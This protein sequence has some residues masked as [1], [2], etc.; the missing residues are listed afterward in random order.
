M[1]GTPGSGRLRRWGPLLFVA[2]VYGVLGLCLVMTKSRTALLGVLVAAGLYWFVQRTGKWFRKGAIAAIT[3]ILAGMAL[4]TLALL[5][6]II[7][8]QVLSEAPKSLKYRLEYWAATSRMILDHIWLGCGPGN[9]RANYLHHKLAGASEEILDP[10][11]LLLDVWA[12][13]GIVAW[14]GLVALLI[15]GVR[16]GWR[17]VVGESSAGIANRPL[18]LLRWSEGVQCAL[19]GPALVILQQVGFGAGADERMWVFLMACPF[20]GGWLTAT[21]TGMRQAP[22]WAAWIALSVHLCGAGGIAMPAIF[23]VWSLLLAGLVTPPQRLLAE[24][25]E[26]SEM[27]RAPWLALPISAVIAAGCLTLGVICVRTSLLPNALCRAEISLAL[28]TMA[29]TGRTDRAAQQLIAATEIDPL[30][31]EPWGLLMQLRARQ[32]AGEVTESVVEAGAEA[33]QRNPENPLTYELLG[34]LWAGVDPATEKSRTA[35]IQWYR[36]AALRYPNSA[37]IRASLALA[38]HA[39][40]HAREAVKEAARALKLDDLN[41]AAGHADKVYSPERRDALEQIVKPPPPPASR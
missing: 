28:D 17:A 37:R 24:P 16:T 34:D 23:Q 40:G 39:A 20:L 26:T 10:H 4:A 7:D 1:E 33:I 5:T 2:A 18:P 8:Q 27:P 31:P 15:W 13:A 38:L 35:A 30:N 29:T 25:L 14:A 32:S 11:N 6:G 36:D 21:S 22:I 9:F 3:V 41:Q 19:A 12:N